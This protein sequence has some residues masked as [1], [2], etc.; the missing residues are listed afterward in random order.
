M[1]RDDDPC[2]DDSVP[3]QRRL[4][5]CAW[6]SLPIE[7]WHQLCF[8]DEGTHGI[9]EHRAGWRCLRH[10][11][12]GPPGVKLEYESKTRPDG[13]GWFEARA[14]GDFSGFD[15]A[16]ELLVLRGEVDVE[17]R[18]VVMAPEVIERPR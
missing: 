1:P 15:D 2:R 10:S 9:D 12:V 13:G 8:S 5:E 11:G 3:V 4:R 6:C 7:L 18:T 16:E 17:S 14:V